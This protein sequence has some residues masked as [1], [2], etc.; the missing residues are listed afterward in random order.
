MRLHGA[1]VV[2]WCAEVR[3]AM[4]GRRAAVACERLCDERRRLLVLLE[5][6][7]EEATVL[8][9]EPELS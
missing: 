6:D 9:D 8:E 5:G 3:E 7:H 4:L 1:R 2:A